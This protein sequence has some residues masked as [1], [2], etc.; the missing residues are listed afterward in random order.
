MVY[1]TPIHPIPNFDLTIVH[2]EMFNILIALRLGG[3][4]WQHSVV[5]IFYDNMAVVQ[6]VAKFLAA[7]IRNVWLITAQL[8]LDLSISD[9]KGS[10]NEIADLLSRLHSDKPVDKVLI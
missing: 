3:K 8:D 9:I 4:F 5:N 6:V 2:L 1:S 10:D 7:C